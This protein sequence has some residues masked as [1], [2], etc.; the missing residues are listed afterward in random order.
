M[1]TQEA[2]QILGEV[3]K[4]AHEARRRAGRSKIDRQD[5]DLG[6]VNAWKMANTSM[7]LMD[8]RSLVQK[9]SMADSMSGTN[10]ADH[11]SE[12]LTFLK[13]YHDLAMKRDIIPDD[14]FMQEL[15]SA[16]DGT[17][18]SIRNRLRK[19]YG[20]SF[21]KTAEGSWRVTDRPKPEPPPP[22]PEP[23]PVLSQQ[24]LP[25]ADLP[26]IPLRP[27]TNRPDA[28]IIIDKLDTIIDVLLLLVGHRGV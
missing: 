9:A 19:T 12:K 11:K 14:D 7:N 22:A 4:V 3:M 20:F 13:R 1:E 6:W 8:W 18:S 10:G 17:F 27:A 28:Q 24:V 5:S 26:D 2:K 16:G 15:W 25:L 23:A 21:T